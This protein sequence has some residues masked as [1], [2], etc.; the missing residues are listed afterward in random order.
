MSD[1]I[2]V[3]VCVS[4]RCTFLSVTNEHLRQEIVENFTQGL[5]S[6]NLHEVG[7]FVRINFGLEFQT[8]LDRDG[9]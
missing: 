5:T 3:C 2:C 8:R 9:S 7:S 4:V 6:H 1:D